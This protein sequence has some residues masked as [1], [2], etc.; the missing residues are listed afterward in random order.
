VNNFEHPNWRWVAN[1]ADEDEP[2]V[3]DDLGLVEREWRPGKT[4][5]ALR[6]L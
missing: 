1:R 6:S 4:F 3:S 5:M 2:N